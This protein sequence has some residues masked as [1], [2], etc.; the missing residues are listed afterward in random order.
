M[1][2]KFNPKRMERLLGPERR[3]VL[4]P[5]EVLDLLPLQPGHVVA[6]TGCGPGYF[7][8]PLARHVPKGKVY[9]LDVQDEMVKAAKEYADA[10]GVTNVEALLSSETNVPVPPNSLDGVFMAFVLHEVDG[11]KA[12]FL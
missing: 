1:P 6:D 3:Q 11:N 9:A 12:N 4:D 7:T 10:E 2:H 8:V 5:D